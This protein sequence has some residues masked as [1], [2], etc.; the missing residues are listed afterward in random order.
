MN[1]LTYTTRIV[2][3]LASAERELAALEASGVNWD[4]L[5]ELE[6]HDRWMGR[7]E[8]L[9]FEMECESTGFLWG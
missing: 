2:Q 8:I 6:N 1:A 5:D 9:S 3:D 7:H 4:D